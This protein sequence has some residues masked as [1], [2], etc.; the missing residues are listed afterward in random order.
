MTITI[1]YYASLSSPW[2]YFGHDRFCA[3]AKKHG[4]TV[5]FCPA[6]FT[7]IFSATG[8]L[9]LP[10]RSPERRA[11]RYQELKR[12]R[13]ELNM[14]LNLDPKFFPV[15]HTKAALVCMALKAEGGNV[16]D[17]ASAYL[18][19]VWV[20]EKDI[21]DDATVIQVANDQGLD[22]QTLFSAGQSA[23]IQSQYEQLSLDAIKKGVFGAPS[24]VIDDE[25]FWGQDRLV[26]VEK[27]LEKVTKP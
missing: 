14:P 10:K 8:G 3:L 17:L 11:Y 26:F 4:A 19:A 13:E 22:G 12:W 21:T 9:P 5:N 15:P 16:L 6:E 2:T 18:K 24:Y 20:E 23:E 25:I 7:T 1:D 27:K